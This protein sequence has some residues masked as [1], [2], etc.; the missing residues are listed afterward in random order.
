MSLKSQ[1]DAEVEDVDF[2]KKNYQ[3]QISTSAGDIFVDL[4]GDV[5]PEHCKNMIGLARLG[6]YNDKI[7]HR[8]IDGFMIQGG[9]PEGTG[10]GGP[11]YKVDAEFNSIPHE[12]GVLSAARSADPNSAGSQFFICLGKHEHLDGQYTAYGRAT[13]ESMQVVANIGS[14]KIGA[15]DRPVEDVTIDKMTVVEI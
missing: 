1:V 11:G 15:N 8:I 9:C 5:A 13:D 6:F 3:V 14:A 4:L 7:F 10:T 12:A 2:E